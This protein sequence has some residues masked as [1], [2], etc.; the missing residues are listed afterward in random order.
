MPEPGPFGETFFEASVLYT[1]LR[2]AA[3]MTSWRRRISDL[4][5]ARSSSTATRCAL[6]APRSTKS[7]RKAC[8]VQTWV[9][10]SQLIVASATCVQPSADRAQPVTGTLAAI[11][12]HMRPP[13]WLRCFANNAKT[14]AHPSTACSAR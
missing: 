13:Q 1:P 7:I 10:W 2:S 11:I 6:G 8:S 5:D 12:V 9:A 3:A 14:L 4:P